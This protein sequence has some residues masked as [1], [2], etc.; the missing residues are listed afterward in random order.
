MSCVKEVPCAALKGIK[1]D[2]DKLDWS[3]L[4]IEPVEDV[5]KVLMFVE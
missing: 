1:Y 3:L 4:P 5:I 2:A